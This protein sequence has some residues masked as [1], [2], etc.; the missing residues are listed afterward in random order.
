[1]RIAPK[2]MLTRIIPIILIPDRSQ[3]NAPQHS[4]EDIRITQ[5]Y[6]IVQ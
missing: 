2:Q 5:E 3:T 1:M 4:Q 6:L